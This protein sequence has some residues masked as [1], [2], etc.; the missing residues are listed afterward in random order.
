MELNGNRRFMNDETTDK[1]SVLRSVLTKGKPEI[2]VKFSFGWQSSVHK[3]ED[4]YQSSMPAKSK[5]LSYCF[6]GEDV[7]RVIEGLA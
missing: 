6:L 2:I 4:K 7:R 5:D 3:S 1:H